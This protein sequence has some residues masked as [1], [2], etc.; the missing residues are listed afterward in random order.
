MKIRKNDGTYKE[1]IYN[2]KQLLKYG[3]NR[4]SEREFSRQELFKKMKNLQP[5]EAMVNGILDKLTEMGYLSD[6][7][8]AKMLYA[9]YAQREGTYKIKMRLKDKGI[10]QEL[11]DSLL[12]EKQENAEEEG[13]GELQKAFEILQRKF[14]VFDS[15]KYAKMSRFLFSRGFNSDAVKRALDQLKRQD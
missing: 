3:L 11:I 1:I 13:S 6:E 5:E 9:Q 4:L 14:Q 10:P 2:E 12:S 8:R 7:R 15:E